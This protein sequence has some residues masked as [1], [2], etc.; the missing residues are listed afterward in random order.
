MRFLQCGTA[1]ADRSLPDRRSFSHD[2]HHLIAGKGFE[3]T[4]FIAIS[5]KPDFLSG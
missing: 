2:G 3:A 1:I 4:F 5:S